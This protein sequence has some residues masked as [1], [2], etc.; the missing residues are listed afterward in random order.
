M[1]ASKARAI[2]VELVA[3]VPPEQWEERLA[4]LA[5]EDGAL[6]D[7]VAALLA[8][9]RKADSFL[10][11]PAAPIGETADDAG[12]T[13]A[14]LDRPAAGGEPAETAGAVLAGRF[15]LLEAIG[16]GG[17]G[18][19]WMAQ[20]TEPVR[21]LVAVKLIKAGMDSKQVIARFGAERQ[22]LALMD[23]PNIARVLDGGTTSAGRPYFVMDLVKGT[24]ITRYCDEHRLTPTQ[25]L[26]GRRLGLPPI[27]SGPLSARITHY[28]PPARSELV[29]LSHARP[30]PV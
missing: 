24:S 6:R 2:F 13:P 27:F 18:A 1:S 29:R 14:P 17:M 23:H 3:R 4:V 21:R 26:T 22:A 25:R 19:V 28:L 11:H 9:H 8:A 12:A 5:G 10:E 7:R 15:K 16:E 20:Q 30:A